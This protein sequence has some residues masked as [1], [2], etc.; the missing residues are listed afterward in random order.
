MKTVAILCMVMAYAILAGQEDYLL[1]KLEHR[2]RQLEGY[3]IT[4]QV[5]FSLVKPISSEDQNLLEKAG[6]SDITYIYNIK[7]STEIKVALY[8]D[9]ISIYALLPA[10]VA[11][12]T[13]FQPYSKVQMIEY[14][15]VIKKGY[16]L[17][18]EGRLEG[19]V[20]T[21]NETF[22]KPVPFN[23][24]MVWKDST[25]TAFLGNPSGFPAANWEPDRFVILFLS[26]G[27]L[28]QIPGMRFEVQH[29]S[30][31]LAYLETKVDRSLV[32]IWYK[33]GVSIPLKMMLETPFGKREFVTQSTTT[34]NGVELI[35]K[36]YCKYGNDNLFFR[37][38]KF[39][40]L[41][42]SKFPDLLLNQGLTVFD[43]RLLGNTVTPKD[44]ANDENAVIYKWSGIVPEEEALRRFAYQQGSLVPPEIPQRRY[45][46][47]LFVPAALFFL[48][49]AYLYLRGKRK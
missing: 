18:A 28:R 36:F 41:N 25:S 17:L 23:S 21:Q 46:L 32:R 48:A 38:K 9:S 8:K 47:W 16:D 11:P 30:N 37:L 5:D 40:K 2:S 42:H 33:Q 7:C 3:L 49:A 34:R 14:Y 19:F 39:E 27:A 15:R 44:L 12:P 10:Q 45:S 6:K 43:F 4:W 13:R 24:V 26:N 1:R 22:P 35:E 20:G 31:H 29:A